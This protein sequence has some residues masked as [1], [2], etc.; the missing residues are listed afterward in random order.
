MHSLSG[1]GFDDRPSGYAVLLSMS[2]LFAQSLTK[3][4][5]VQPTS[6]DF[7]LFIGGRLRQLPIT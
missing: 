5:E 2:L 4:A 3:I 7:S 1:M 6:D